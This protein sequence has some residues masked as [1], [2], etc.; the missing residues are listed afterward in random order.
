MYV[1][2]FDFQLFGCGGRLHSEES[3]S[4]IHG[5]PGMRAQGFFRMDAARALEVIDVPTYKRFQGG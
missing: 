4:P 3:V 5:R 1:A 2:Y